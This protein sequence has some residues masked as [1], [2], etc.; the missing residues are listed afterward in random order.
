MSCTT[1]L[2][3]TLISG[4]KFYNY[5]CFIILFTQSFIQNYIVGNKE[6]EAQGLDFDY[7]P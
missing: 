1:Y 7:N 6:I 4:A 2:Y 3:W 5:R